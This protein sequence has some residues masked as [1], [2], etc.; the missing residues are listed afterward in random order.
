MQKRKRKRGEYLVVRLRPQG[1]S[2]APD[3]TGPLFVRD[4]V[5]SRSTRHISI[6]SA[7]VALWKA[8]KPGKGQEEGRADLR[9]HGRLIATISRG[10]ERPTTAG[11][12]DAEVTL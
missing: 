9:R 6:T 11:P 2:F 10:R 4:W 1:M 5:V 12:E 3:L 7:V 8:A